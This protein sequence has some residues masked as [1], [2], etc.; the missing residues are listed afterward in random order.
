MFYKAKAKNLMFNTFKEIHDEWM[1]ITAGDINDFNT[2]TANWGGFGVLW[3]YNTA[4]IFVRESRYTKEFLDKNDTF[5]LSFFSR[6][7]RDALTFC[8]QNSGRDFDKIKETK[9]KPI[10]LEGNVGF[11]QADT[12]FVC[13]KILATELG[14]DTIIAKENLKKW[15]D[16]KD[17]H[18]MYIGEILTIFNKE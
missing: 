4:I 15:Y 2:M 16:T 17:Y 9:L 11:E 1:L 10:E 3:H 12:I 5:T 13:K 6:R 7:Y 14:P 8:G 18:T